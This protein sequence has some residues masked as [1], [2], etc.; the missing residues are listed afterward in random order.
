M[1][2]SDAVGHSSSGDSA[3]DRGGHSRFLTWDHATLAQ[4]AHEANERVKEMESDLK[5]AM[6]AYRELLRRQ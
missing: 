4:F 1:Q 6:A 3:A 5:A 2:Q